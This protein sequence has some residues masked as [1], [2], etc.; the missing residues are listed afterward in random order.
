VDLIGEGIKLAGTSDVSIYAP[1]EFKDSAGH[2]WKRPIMHVALCTD[3]A[4]PGLEGFIPLPA[5][6]GNTP[7]RVPVLKLETT[8]MPL[9]PNAPAGAPP[10]PSNALKD[11]FKQQVHAVID[12]DTLDIPG[13]IKKIKAILQAQEKALG[14]IEGAPPEPAPGSAVPVAATLQPTPMEL[15]LSRKSRRQDFDA[16]VAAGKLTPAARDKL[17]AIYLPSDDKALSLSLSQAGCDQFDAMI[18]ALAENDPVKL[19]EKT[20]PQLL[21]LS[22]SKQGPDEETKKIQVETKAAVAR[23]AG[24]KILA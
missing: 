2:A 5:S 24:V 13:K 11:A 18:A 23:L 20:G 15:R 22:A 6:K 10:A 12:D 8:T 16:L 1:P 7:V 9:D 21:S 3:P 19:G 17:A 4:I 14:L